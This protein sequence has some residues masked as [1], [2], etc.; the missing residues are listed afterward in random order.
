MRRTNPDLGHTI[1]LPIHP[2]VS[3]I[4]TARLNLWFLRPQR[5]TPR[6]EW[7]LR[8]QKNYQRRSKGHAIRGRRPDRLSAEHPK[9]KD[10]SSSDPP[11]IQRA[12]RVPTTHLGGTRIRNCGKRLLADTCWDGLP[13]AS[14]VLPAGDS[15]VLN[16]KLNNEHSLVGCP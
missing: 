3:T 14:L 4:N 15:L 13:G 6:I 12:R 9:R 8:S 2:V 16:V 1:R 10:P 5:V 11:T 7:S